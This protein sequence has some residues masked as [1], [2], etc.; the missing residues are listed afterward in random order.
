[1]RD[2]DWRGERTPSVFLE[3]GGREVEG[4]N[5]EVKEGEMRKGGYE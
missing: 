4:E 1:M 2:K 5:M 3:R